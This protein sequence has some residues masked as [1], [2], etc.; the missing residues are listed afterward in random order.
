MFEATERQSFLDL[1]RPPPGYRLD[2]ALGTTYSLDF[3]ALTA[4]LMAFVDAES[5][6]EDSSTAGPE[7][8]QAIT[9]LVERVRVFVNRAEIHGPSK[10]NRMTVFYDRI[11]REVRLPGGCF[12]PKVW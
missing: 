7:A 12:H 9:R 8:L 10:V 6:S 2:S 4:A 3:V 11:I 5:E 1:L